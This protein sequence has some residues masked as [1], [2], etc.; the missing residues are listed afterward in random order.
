MAAVFPIDTSQP[1]V[2]NGVTYVYNADTGSW[3][4]V[5]STATENLQD[6]EDRLDAIE[7]GGI[8]SGLSYML[9]TNSITGGATPA[10]DLVDSDDGFSNVK[11]EGV[12]GIN[13]TSTGSSIVIDGSD[14]QAIADLNDYYTKTEVDA[15]DQRLQDQVDELLITKGSATVYTLNEIGI[16]VGI[17]PGDFY[18]DNA[19]VKEVSFIA[20]SPLDDNNKE[21]PLGAVGDIVELVTTNNI[22]YRYQISTAGDGLAG[23][24]FLVGANPDD[25]LTPGT[26]FNVYVYPQNKTTA[27]IDYV[28]SGLATKLPKSG[29]LMSGNIVMGGTANQI[30]TNNSYIRFGWGDIN[31]T[32]EYGGY[33]YMRNADTFEIG[34]YTGKTLKFIGQPL[35]DQSPEVPTPTLDPH[36]ASKYYVD[37]QIGGLQSSIGDYLPLT[38]GTIT[39]NLVLETGSGLYSK[40]IIK[41]TRATG[42]AFQVRPSDGDETSHIHTNGNVKFAEGIFTGNV[43]LEG[44]LLFTNGGIIN[45]SSGNTVLSGRASLDIKSAAD[46]PVV[47]SSG[48]SYKKVLA[49]YGYNGSEDDNRG[50]VASIHANGNAYFTSVFAGDKELSTRTYVDGK[51]ADLFSIVE[52]EDAEP[53][54]HYGTTTPTESGDGDLWVDTTN[55]RLLMR[56]NGAWVNPDRQDSVVDLSPYQKIVSPPGRKFKKLNATSPNTDG[57]FTYY[58]TNGQVKLGL[59]RRDAEGTKWLDISFTDSLNVPVLFRIIQWQNNTSHKTIRYGAI[60]KIVA[61]DGGQVVCDVKYHQTNGSLTN[62]S[63]YFI[64]IGGL[65]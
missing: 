36:A 44:N 65:I 41:S 19:V 51:V 55:M 14:V 56:V 29:G 46:Y 20:L 26:T 42:Y 23:V 63:N 33:V 28:D 58:E 57:S 52:A 6:L 43:N 5:G 1:W 49:I 62:G 27:S 45:V 30:M 21:R 64:I 13:V 10:I 17:R 25:V 60:D 34:T 59:N 7:A 2:N 40:E 61:T 8:D 54:I 18:V 16:Q 12:N 53:D 32:E 35:F 38:G 48:S 15:A 24:E 31:T 11:I 39:G 22:A 47:I 9:Q 37:N 4:A 50:E 3:Q